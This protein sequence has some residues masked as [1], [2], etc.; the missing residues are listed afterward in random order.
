MP[1]P[2]SLDLRQ[3]IVEAY[4]SGEGF[5]S[6]IAERFRV[7]EN[8]VS[9][10]VRRHRKTGSIAPTPQRRGPELRIRDEHAPLLETWLAEDSSLTQAELAHRFSETT[11]RSVSQQSV[12]RALSRLKITR[13]K[14]R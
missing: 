13:K 6:D 3:R 7:S 9:R 4:L 2:L 10:L 1:A 12:S 14:R 5:Q 8:T 11:G